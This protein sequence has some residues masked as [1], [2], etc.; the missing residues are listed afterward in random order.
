MDE[1]EGNGTREREETASKNKGRHDSRYAAWCR[2]EKNKYSEVLCIAYTD[3]GRHNNTHLG[4]KR[5]TRRYART[6]SCASRVIL[7]ETPDLSA[8]LERGEALA[9]NV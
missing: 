4:E 8:T 2:L 5:T 7:S 9:S 6:R 3:L 1:Q